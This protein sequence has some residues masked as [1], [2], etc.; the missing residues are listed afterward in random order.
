MNN[1]FGSKGEAMQLQYLAAMKT[2]NDA[3]AEGAKM[4]LVAK[5]KGSL[6]PEVAERLAEEGFN[7]LIKKNMSNDVKSE[8]I[9]YLE[10]NDDEKGSVKV[11]EVGIDL[12]K[13]VDD[14]GTKAK[15]AGKVIKG[16]LKSGAKKGLD[17]LEV[18]VKKA[19]EKMD[20]VDEDEDTGYEEES[21]PEDE[22]DSEGADFTENE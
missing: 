17:F 20:A 9:V 19:K 2:I 8:N 3:R 10:K 13:V 11:I 15:K 21:M 1:T 22:N 14:A 4:T 12:Q 16:C 7:V 6:Y 18:V 5:D